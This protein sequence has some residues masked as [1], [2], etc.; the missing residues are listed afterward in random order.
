MIDGPPLSIDDWLRELVARLSGAN[1]RRIDDDRPLIG[2]GLDS[3]SMMELQAAVEDE[4]GVVVPVSELLDGLTLRELS[5]RLAGAAARELSERSPPAGEASGKLASAA[6]PPE[7]PALSPGQR[8]LWVMHRL[9]P[10][11]SAYTLAAAVRVIAGPGAEWLRRA[12]QVLLDRHASLRTTF[13]RGLDG[14]VPRVEERAALAWR[15]LDASGWDRAELERRLRAEAFQPFDLERGPV[16]RA[17]LFAGAAG[18]DVLVIAVHHLAADFAS[19]GVLARELRALAAGGTLASPGPPPIADAVRLQ[20]AALAGGGGEAA[21][22]WWYERLAGAPPLDLPTDLPRPPVQGFRGGARTALLPLQPVTDLARSRQATPFMA[23]L[24]AFMA[25]LARTSGQEDFLVSTPLSQRSADGFGGGGGLARQFSDTVGYL[26]NLVALR[27]TLA[28]DLPAGDLVERARREALAAFAHQEV[29]FALL[30]ERLQAERGAGRPPLLQAMLVLHRPPAAELEALGALA[31]GLGGARLE[32][33]D[34][35]LESLPLPNPGAQFDLGLQAAEL[36]G[37]LAVSL[38]FDSDLFDAVSAERFLG[39]FANLLQ[40]MAAE[41][42]RSVWELDL[43]SAAELGELAAWNATAVVRGGDAA[44][45]H[46]LFERQVERT[47]FAPAVVAEGEGAAAIVT[48]QELNRRANRLARHLR[49]LGVGPERRV[50]V[51]LHRTPDL[52]IG[53]LGVL[54]AGGAYVPLDPSYPAER[55]ELMASDAGVG[56]LVTV[57]ELAGRLGGAGLRRVRLDAEAAAIAGEDGGNPAPLGGPQGLAY[58]IYTSGSSGR[59]K[60]VAIEHRSPVDLVQWARGSFADQELAGVLAATSVCFDLSVF[61]LFVPLAWGGRVILAGNALALPELTAAA[62]VTLLNTVPSAMAELAAGE[63]PPGLLAVNLAGEALPLRLVEQIRRHRQVR[64]IRNLYGPTEDTTYSTAA[65]IGPDEGRITIGRPLDNTR[66]HL[67]DL[68]LRPVPVGVVGEICLAGAGLARGY[69]GRPDLTAERFIPDPCGGGGGRLYRT[70]DLARRLADGR[71]E[72]LGRRDQQVKVR[73]FRIELGEVEAALAGHPAVREVT[74]TARED[75]PGGRALVAYVVPAAAQPTAAELRSF[76]RGKLPAH[77][78]PDHVV[79]LDRIPRTPS[80]KVDRRGLPPPAGSGQEAARVPPRTPIEEIV[81]AVWAEL[82]GLERVEAHGDFFALGG[83]SLLAPRAMARLHAAL[84]VELPLRQLFATPTVAGLA[85]AVRAARQGEAGAGAT[86]AA[87]AGAAAAAAL[88]PAPALVRLPRAAD[89]GGVFPLSFAQERLWFLE[90]LTP[91]Q[92]AYNVPAAVR[93][94]GRLAVPALRRALAQAVRRHEALRTTYAAPGGS[95]VQVVWGPESAVARAA[96]ALPVV[97][98]SGLAPAAA[99]AA[100]QELSAAAAR[101]PFALGSG[102]L[103]RSALVR[104]T[105]DE[106][107]LV[108]DV[109]HLAADGWS[110]R[111][112]AGEL[113]AGYGA[114]LRGEEPE[115]GALPVQYGDYAAW[116]RQAQSAAA[117]AADLGWWRERLAGAPE[118]SSPP[119]DR[120]RPAARGFRGAIEAVALGGE[121]VG[122]LRGLGRQRGATLFMVL[123]AGWSALCERW[124]GQSDLVVGTAVANRLRPEVEGLIG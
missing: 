106:Q 30:A 74:V 31:L 21:R 33:G 70:G 60:G 79:L 98:L 53:L 40:G 27:A 96:A 49:R 1:P 34:L 32:L 42:G 45:L 16:L 41:P 86:A 109:H 38:S 48:Y 28:G 91:G 69:L 104:L 5:G 90:R 9:A 22:D 8:A 108:V 37:R 63:L 20:L 72:F 56:V 3:L 89:G 99:E 92:A 97:D 75:L 111:V 93:L 36:D 24:A 80:G 110:L 54:K 50:G 19:F 13:D 78:I 23:V 46:Q 39:H 82:L 113:G 25:L 88:P 95:P 123:L 43:L 7:A 15:L 77:L 61:E 116:Q 57:D 81:A 65:E 73:G 117:L 14:P 58:V 35:V 66:V 121:L 105:P 87:G 100:A 124:T 85:A 29:P 2:W 44:C 115:L 51:L 112:L 62:E 107:L 118:M 18:G 103:L 26:V 47:P 59:P 83:H 6:T 55:L 71:I 102:P 101:R 11:S 10:E 67:L 114:A 17:A 12:L 119:G 122:G 64:R 4:L 94:S 68:R 52:L 76:L 84:G 120:P